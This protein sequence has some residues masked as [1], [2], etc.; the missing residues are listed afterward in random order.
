MDPVDAFVV[1]AGFLL[2]LCFFLR[3]LSL[4]L[5]GSDNLTPLDK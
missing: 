2:W 1:G 4:F 5:W 3:L